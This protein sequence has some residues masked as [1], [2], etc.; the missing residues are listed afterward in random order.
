MKHC[1]PGVYISVGKILFNH[2]GKEKRQE[3]HGEKGRDMD[4]QKKE[5]FRKEDIKEMKV[6]VS[7]SG[8]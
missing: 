1:L 3:R 6:K 2:H 5:G 8:L 4:R 7:F